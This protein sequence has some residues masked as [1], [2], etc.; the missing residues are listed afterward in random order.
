MPTECWAIQGPQIEG[1]WGNKH[2]SFI[3]DLA[4]LG[5]WLKD[6]SG[7]FWSVWSQSGR[8]SFLQ[9][10]CTPGLVPK[11]SMAQSE[12]TGSSRPRAWPHTGSSGEQ[13]WARLVCIC[14]KVVESTV[15]EKNIPLIRRIILG[16]VA[17]ALKVNPEGCL[18]Q[19]EAQ[20]PRFPFPSKPD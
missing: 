9:V 8:Q 18:S 5:D 12:G 3:H 16:W 11:H 13:T 10:A 6:S 7:S 1:T 19:G 2:A 15:Q 17:G 14:P 4:W 20:S